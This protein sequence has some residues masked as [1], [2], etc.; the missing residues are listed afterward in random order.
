[1]PPFCLLES[2]PNSIFIDCENIVKYRCSK[3]FSTIRQSL[4]AMKGQPL[5][6]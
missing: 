3:R 5:A 6:C 4:E 2:L 1:M